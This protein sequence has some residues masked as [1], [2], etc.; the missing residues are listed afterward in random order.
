MGKND[1]YWWSE[2]PLRPTERQPVPP[3]ADVAIVGAGYTGLSAAIR[4][5][6]A[7][8][9]VQVFDKQDPGEGAS[10][11]NGGIT[12]GNLRPGTAELTRRFGAERAFAIQAEAK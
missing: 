3:A 8:R 2:A 10:T 5:A 7:G 9:S 4:L 6:R 12:S 11:R 1:V